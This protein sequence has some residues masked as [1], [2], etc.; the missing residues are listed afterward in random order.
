[1]RFYP[2]AAPSARG[3][4]LAGVRVDPV[5]YARRQGVSFPAYSSLPNA[6]VDLI[7]ALNGSGKSVWLNTL[8]LGAI[9]SPGLKRLPLITIIDIG[10]SSSGL[11]DL[12]QNALPPD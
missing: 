7:L 2:D 8:N 9:L 11:I 3:V 6:W 10:P 4:S 1:M 5:A 12:L